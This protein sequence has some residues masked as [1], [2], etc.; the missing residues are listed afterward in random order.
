MV[1]E[2]DCGDGIL[3]ESSICNGFDKGCFSCILQSDDS[4]LKL[5]VEE[6]GFDPW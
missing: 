1:I 3:F 4:N 2:A 5:F 6:F